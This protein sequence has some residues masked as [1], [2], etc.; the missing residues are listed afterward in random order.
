MVVSYLRAQH[1]KETFS[2]CRTWLLS[3]KNW[4][5]FDQTDLSE[6][7]LDVQRCKWTRIFW[8][9]ILVISMYRLLA[10]LLRSEDAGVGSTAWDEHDLSILCV[11]TLGLIF[12]LPGLINPRSQDFLYIF[13]M[14]GLDAVYFIQALGPLNID[15][16]DV[17]TVA[18]AARFF[19]AVMARRIGCVCFCMLVH[20]LQAT[21]LSRLQEDPSGK[22]LSPQSLFPL[23]LTL[24][25][26]VIGVRRLMRQ[27]VLLRVNLQK[28]TVEMEAVSSLLT[29]CYD[30]VVEVDHTLKLTQDS[31]LY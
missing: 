8:W 30:A 18:F 24:F 3:W 7:E 10:R 25:I 2:T 13:S 20:F 5:N 19:Y 1:L 31:K 29:A 14:V 22:A 16:R 11:A 26:G 15:V 27:N 21:Q 28:R 6:Q 4:W 9:A 23:F 12:T 17:I